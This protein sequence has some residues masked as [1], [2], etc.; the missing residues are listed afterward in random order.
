MWFTESVTLLNW[1]L[2]LTKFHTFIFFPETPLTLATKLKKC[3]KILMNLVN[4]GAILDFRTKDGATSMHRA[5]EHNN[6][7]AVTTLLELGASPNYKDTK[8][9][10]PLYVSI[11]HQTDPVICET[12]LHDRAVV[13]I[14]DLQGWQEVHQVCHQERDKKDFF[15]YFCIEVHVWQFVGLNYKRSHEILFAITKHMIH[16]FLLLVLFHFMNLASN[17]VLTLYRKYARNFAYYIIIKSEFVG[18]VQHFRL[19]R[20]CEMKL[21]IV[22]PHLTGMVYHDLQ[23]K[24]LASNLII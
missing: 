14:Q 23:N 12:L 5:V 6:V 18:R 3:S 22:A 7:E 2:D 15:I 19:F 9:I 10:T 24:L 21:F 16:P 4:G 17:F 20:E 8:G 1:L 11:T 13:G